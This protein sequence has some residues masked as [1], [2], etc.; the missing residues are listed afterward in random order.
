MF[1][2]DWLLDETG[3]WAGFKQDDNGNGTWDL[4]QSRTSND[5]NEITDIT[6]TAGSPWVTPAYSAAGNAT[7]MPQPATPTSSYTATYDA[8][9]RLVKIVDGS[10]TVSEYQY[11][12]AKRRIV[13]K[14]YVVSRSDSASVLPNPAN[15][16]SWKNASI[17]PPTPTASSSGDRVH[18]DD[19]IL[20]DRNYHRQQHPRRTPLRLQD[21]NWNVTSLIDTSG[22]VQ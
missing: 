19:L 4:N 18:I 2:Q 7:T 22:T 11:D 9:N 3:N 12:G 5:V 16:R 10:N 8:R 13:Q 17:L 20:R 14:E 15:G 6:E 21:A 1:A